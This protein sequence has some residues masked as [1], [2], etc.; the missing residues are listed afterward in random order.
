MRPT[1]VARTTS[2]GSSAW[3]MEPH[4]LG[5]VARVGPVAHRGE[6][7]EDERLVAP[8]A[9]AA[10]ARVTLRLTYAAGGAATRG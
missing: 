7:T 2:P 8:R 3:A 5:D 4:G 6:V 9:M 10:T 1:P